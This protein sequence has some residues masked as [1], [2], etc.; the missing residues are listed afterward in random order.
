M[1]YLSRS[2]HVIVFQHSW[3]KLWDLTGWDNCIILLPVAVL[4]SGTCLVFEKVGRETWTRL[5]V[6]MKLVINGKCSLYINEGSKVVCVVAL[7]GK[8]KA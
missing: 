7:I 8:D 2:I 1:Y 4:G 3:S 6:G 5:D